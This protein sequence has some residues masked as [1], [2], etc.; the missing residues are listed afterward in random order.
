[1]K[2]KLIALSALTILGAPM[3]LAQS[4]N[5]TVSTLPPAE[6][7]VGTRAESLNPSAF[8]RTYKYI[9]HV[10]LRDIVKY[11]NEIGRKLPDS[12]DRLPGTSKKILA[13][14]LDS[15]ERFIGVDGVKYY[16]DGAKGPSG[17]EKSVAY[18][19]GSRKVYVISKRHSNTYTNTI[20]SVDYV[21]AK[22]IRPSVIEAEL[23]LFAHSDQKGP[24]FK[25]ITVIVDWKKNKTHEIEDVVSVIKSG[26]E[27]ALSETNFVLKGS[28]ADQKII[29]EDQNFGITKVFPVTV[30]AIDARD[31]IVESMNF[32]VP[33]SNRRAA[34]KAGLDP[35]LQN[36]F[37]DFSN[38]ALISRKIW[39][40]G[41]SWAN[42]S[43]RTYPSAFKGRPFIGLVDLNYVDLTSGDK[44]KYSAGYREIGLHYQITSNR[45]E[46]GFRSHGCVRVRDKD[47]YQLDV[48]V[49]QNA[50]KDLISAVFKNT[51]PKYKNINHPHTY[52]KSVAMVMY[53]S[54]NASDYR[55]K[56]KS[57]NI[58]CQISPYRQS[59]SVRW[60]DS[61]RKDY[62]TVIGNDCLTTTYEDTGV[63]SS[64]VKAYL[65]GT[66]SRI[67]PY[68]VDQEHGP[69]KKAIETLLSYN[70][71]SSNV[72]SMTHK[73]RMETILDIQNGSIIR[74]GTRLEAPKDS[75]S[76]SSNFTQ[77]P[78][79]GLRLRDLISRSSYNRIGDKLQSRK[80]VS[81]TN[82]RK[83]YQRAYFVFCHE[84]EKNGGQPLNNCSDIRRAAGLN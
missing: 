32:H 76:T 17:S 48:I 28:I 37:Q 63:T 79:Y 7:S 3:A 46:R 64:E 72:N 12:A 5:I 40:T 49:N 29:I 43:E 83:Y 74:P 71:S 70:Y 58:L 10:D 50:K 51:L 13:A 56:A 23:L 27:I 60:N 26:E 68:I 55:N 47:L 52:N 22:E 54:K 35:A 61:D 44:I 38:A 39:N 8:I 53:T 80:S 33:A 14:V 59:R 20:F 62:H 66:G 73:K 82:K 57:E 34:R 69:V 67:R 1:M 77:W 42:T 75:F 65:E 16:E 84:K 25:K 24:F 15:P 19:N 41:S 81:R 11:D 6:L 78:S 45:L 21:S 9:E 36:E 18:K 4:S 31:S 30:G 2:K